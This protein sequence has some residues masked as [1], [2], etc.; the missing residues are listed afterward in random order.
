MP[1]P[2]AL[3]QCRY[4]RQAVRG[5]RECRKT[6]EGKLEQNLARTALKLALDDV[7]KREQAARDE[8]RDALRKAEEARARK[9]V[10]AAEATR[11]EREH[12]AIGDSSSREG[13]PDAGPFRP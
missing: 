12:N 9:E 8:Q 2:E 13:T 1:T 6:L 5:V 10:A 7:R 4:L 3:Q 11:L